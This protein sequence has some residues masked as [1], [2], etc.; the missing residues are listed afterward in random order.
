MELQ[1]DMTLRWGISNQRD[2]IKNTLVLQRYYVLLK[3][4][5]YFLF[6]SSNH[7]KCFSCAT[8]WEKK[9]DDSH[10]IFENGTI[11]EKYFPHGRDFVF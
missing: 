1:G 10:Q 9:M 8:K 6:E 2:H 5:N 7:F 11:D 3:I 4:W